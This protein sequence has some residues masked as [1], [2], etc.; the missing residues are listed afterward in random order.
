MSMRNEVLKTSIPMLA[1]AMSGFRGIAG[2]SAGFSRNLM[3][4]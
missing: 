3:I 1:S 4:R 2:R